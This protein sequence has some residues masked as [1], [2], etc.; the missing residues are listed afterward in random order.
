MKILIAIPPEKFRDEELA[1]PVAAL[2]KAW[3]DFEI[4]STR[5]GPCTGMLGAMAVAALTFEDVDPK[6]YDGL[7]IVGGSGSPSHLW[8]DDL[9]V[10]L[11]R[12]MAEVKNWLL[13]SASLRW[14][15]R[16]PAH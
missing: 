14:Y 9:L 8:D 1:E 13:R 6:N 3:I 10:Q 4:A 12:Y 11:T 5:K 15:L 16:K 2:Q 7:I